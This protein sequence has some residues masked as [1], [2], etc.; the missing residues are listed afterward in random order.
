MEPSDYNRLME[1]NVVHVFSERDPARR[2]SAIRKLYAEDAVL[3]EPDHQANGAASISEAVTTLL[4]SLPSGFVFTP[5]GP[6]VGHHGV[7]RLRW[8]AGP[9]DGRTAATGTDVAHFKAGRI[10]ALYVF[11][12]PAP[13]K[14]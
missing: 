5:I 13:S 4:A 2:L 14:D 1:D 12:D 6:A 7:G 10:V 11:L 8:K 3:Y 9:V